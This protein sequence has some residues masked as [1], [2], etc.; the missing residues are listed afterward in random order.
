[1]NGENAMDTGLRVDHFRD[2][3]GTD[4]PG[5]YYRDLPIFALPGL[6]GFIGD[7]AS[8]FFSSGARILDLGSGSGALALRLEDLGFDVVCCD[9]V[10]EGFRASDG[11]PLV[12]ANLNDSFA[13]GFDTPFDAVTAVEIIEHLENPWH[14]MRQ[15]R[16]LMK[17]GAGMIVTTPNIDTPRSILSFVKYGTFKSFTDH[18]YEKDGHITP[19]SQW[20]LEKCVREAGLEPASVETF[21]PPWGTGLRHLGAKALWLFARKN[22]RKIGSTI[23][24]S[25]RKPAD[26]RDKNTSGH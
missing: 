18:D 15:C 26:G 14:F 17:P 24:A 19:I 13:D 4:E 16:R 7:R 12:R 20:Q 6:H 23:V 2:T 22:P 3:A 8:A 11:I 21:G 9:A 10:P 1:M 5:E 25:I